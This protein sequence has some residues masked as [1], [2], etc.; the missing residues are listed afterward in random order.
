MCLFSN[1]RARK[2]VR[3]AF[4]KTKNIKRREKEQEKSLL[5]FYCLICCI[6]K[7]YPGKREITS[8][9]GM[10]TEK[11]AIEMFQVIII[12]I[13]MITKVLIK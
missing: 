4:V 10:H 3:Y 9:V 2:K 12:I 5:V 11:Y 13:I 8:V 7:R 6:D 1:T